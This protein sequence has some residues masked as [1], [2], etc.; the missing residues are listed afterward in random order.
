MLT[1]ENVREIW[2]SK[3][4]S[5]FDQYL[6]IKN[7]SPAYSPTWKEDGYMDEAINLFEEWAKQNAPDGSTVFIQNIEGKTPLLVID[8]P[9][10]SDASTDTVLLYGHIDKQP[11]MVGWREG[12]DPWSP[13]TDYMQEVQ[14]MMVT[15]CLV[16]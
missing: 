10:N 14:P 12:M 6:K 16:P 15:P 7:V 2:D 3:V 9:S 4:K 13:T 8:I 5:T 1:E 11:E